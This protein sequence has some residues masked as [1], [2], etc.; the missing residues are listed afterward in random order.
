MCKFSDIGCV[1][2]K[3]E[4]DNM[5]DTFSSVTTVEE[6]VCN[7]IKKRGIGTK[8]GKGGTSIMTDARHSCRENSYHTD[9]VSLGQLTHKVIDA[10]SY[11]RLGCVHSSEARIFGFRQDVCKSR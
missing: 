6:G 1:C 4:R 2:A 3:R 7:R 8:S 9:H 11:Q 10:T 5:M